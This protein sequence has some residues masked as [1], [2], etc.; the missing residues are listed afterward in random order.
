MKMT[1]KGND[2]L[3]QAVDSLNSLKMPRMA[4]KL[5]ELYSS[6]SFA[7]MDKLTVLSEIVSAEYTERM[8]RAVNLRLTKS[9]LKGSDADISKCTD[10]SKRQYEPHGITEILASLDFMKDGMNVC[11]LGP[12][13]SGKSYLAKALGALACYKG[14]VLY[15]HCEKLLEEMAALKK[16]DYA[17]F[18]KKMKYIS[19]LD[20][21]ILDDFLIHSITEE[22]E[23]KVLFDILETRNENK[24]STMVCSQRSPDSWTSLILNDEVSSNSVVKRVTKHFTVLINVPQDKQ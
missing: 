11:I 2:I 23:V 20:L 6:P 16:R 1:I 9:T 8:D 19:K 4:A 10:T 15:T 17:K 3:Q 24:R 7:K 5:E 12:S 13:D 22:N 21:L 18:K 14:S